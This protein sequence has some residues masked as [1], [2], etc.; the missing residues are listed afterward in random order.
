MN[1]RLAKI[2]QLAKQGKTRHEIADA[3]SLTYAVISNCCYAHR[4]KTT[5][6][7]RP[8]AEFVDRV[9]QV[10]E[11]AKQGMSRN[12]IAEAL[13]IPYHLVA[14]CCRGH[15]ISTRRKYR[16]LNGHATIKERDVELL[17]YLAEGHTLAKAGEKFGI[18]KQ[19]VSMIARAAGMARR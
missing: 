13:S 18:T 8:P 17:G 4:I 10:R 16:R 7:R 5:Y 2:R 6:K 1:D 14:Q 19:R 9:Q 11:L 15:G 3:L 12:E